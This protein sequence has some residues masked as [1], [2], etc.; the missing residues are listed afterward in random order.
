MLHFWSENLCWGST[1]YRV[2]F[3]RLNYRVYI[4]AAYRLS[5]NIWLK[6]H[7]CRLLFQQIF[8]T[9]NNK[10]LL[11]DNVWDGY[12][13]YSQRFSTC[14]CWK[15]QQ[16]V[17][18]KP[19]VCSYYTMNIN[20]YRIY[21]KLASWPVN[22]QLFNCDV[23]DQR[24]RGKHKKHWITDDYE[25]DASWA[26]SWEE[27]GPSNWNYRTGSTLHMSW[28]TKYCVKCTDYWKDI[29]YCIRRCIYTSQSIYICHPKSNI[30]SV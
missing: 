14:K 8:S 6:Q 29:W 3:H 18:P 4:Q 21:N 28:L 9:C 5:W 23:A 13:T 20:N 16:F 26:Q 19:F 15:L 11:R 25:R 10:I 1:S 2:S 17:A 12:D 7:A 27:D 30:I 22:Q 24:R